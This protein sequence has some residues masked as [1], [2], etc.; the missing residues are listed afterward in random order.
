MSRTTEAL[1]TRAE[2]LKLARI[3]HRE[4]DTLQYLEAVP[5]AD[6]VALRNQATEVLWNADDGVLAKLAAASRLLP[7][8]VSA[9][10]SERAFG[11]LLTARLASRLEPARAV[12]VAGK[13]STGFLA[14][15]AVELD[16]R[17]ASAVIA[18]IPPDRIAEI[19]AELVRRGEWVTAGRF[20]GHLSDGSLEAA[21]DVIDDPALLRIGFVLEDKGRLDAII[22]LL[23]PRRIKGLIVAAAEHDLWLEA[24]DLLSHLG[25]RHRRRFAATALALDQASLESLLAAVIEHDL[26]DEVLIV[27]ETD[28]ALQAELAERL[29]RLPDAQRKA[30]VQRAAQDGTAGRLGVL[31]EAL[32]KI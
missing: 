12:D 11:P 20:V 6:V 27:A 18:G 14:D 3:L 17:R 13:L 7:T 2:I 21:L 28:P 22:A 23:A 24:L 8:A 19:T 4:P 15:V 25:E 26:W 29:P 31:G 1:Q 32:A 5:L 10:I 30:L 9:T 16:P